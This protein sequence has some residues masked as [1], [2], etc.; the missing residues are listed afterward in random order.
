MHAHTYRQTCTHRQTD[1]QPAINTDR[2]T[3]HAHPLGSAQAYLA[4]VLI[5]VQH[6]G[7]IGEDVANICVFEQFRALHVVPGPETLHDTIDLLGLARQPEG[8]QIHPDGD[9][10]RHACTDGQLSCD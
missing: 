1:R 5:C 10:K 6:D 9:V 3:Y 8:V 4:V 7:G 2:Q